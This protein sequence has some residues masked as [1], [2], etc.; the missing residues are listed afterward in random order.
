M[1]PWFRKKTVAMIFASS[2]FLTNN[3]NEGLVNKRGEAWCHKGQISKIICTGYQASE[4][5]NT[6]QKQQIIV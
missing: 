1:I 6:K 4:M 5:A 3:T 2:S